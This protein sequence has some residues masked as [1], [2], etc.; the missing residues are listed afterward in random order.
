MRSRLALGQVG[1]GL[2]LAIESQGTLQLRVGLGPPPSV[3]RRFAPCRRA[4]ASSG[5]DPM[6]ADRWN[7][8]AANA[9]AASSHAV[10]SLLWAASSTSC[11]PRP[12][13]A[14]TTARSTGQ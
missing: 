4:N 11:S 9:A 2:D 8:L 6:S 10:G 1:A 5:S 3:S 14:K 12:S 13:A 7:P